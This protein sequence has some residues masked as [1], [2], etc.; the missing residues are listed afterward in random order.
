MKNGKES[1]DAKPGTETENRGLF[2]KYKSCYKQ[3]R[4]LVYASLERICSFVL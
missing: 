2:T 3:G 1:F 4:L